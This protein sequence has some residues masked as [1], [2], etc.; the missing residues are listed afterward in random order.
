M[1][2]GLEKIQHFK[3]LLTRCYKLEHYFS[4]L[5]TPGYLP[6]EPANHYSDTTNKAIDALIAD[7]TICLPLSSPYF[8]GFIYW[9]S[10][11]SDPDYEQGKTKFKDLKHNQ[12]LKLIR[13]TTI[14]NKVTD[15]K[16]NRQFFDYAFEEFVVLHTI[17]S[18]TPA[19]SRMMHVDEGMH[20][21]Q[22]AGLILI[23]IK[24]F[25]VAGIDGKT[26]SDCCHT[27]C[28]AKGDDCISKVCN[29]IK[30]IGGMVAGFCRKL[31][32]CINCCDDHS[33]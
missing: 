24:A 28:N 10:L 4:I 2:T 15:L 26:C 30:N 7:F 29:I 1:P 18:K 33:N 22:A 16:R 11:V 27:I 12:K 3:I 25:E 13:S 32:D 6:K 8:L 20:Y 21:M 14:H 5:I 9:D 31:C 17:M 19:F 23:S